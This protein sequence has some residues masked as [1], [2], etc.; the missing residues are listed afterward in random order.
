MHIPTYPPLN[1]TYLAAYLREYSRYKYIIRLVDINSSKDPIN[2]ILKFRPDI[3]G[4]TTL[5]SHLIEICEISKKIRSI[6]KNILL[7]CGGA[8]AAISP[9]DLLINGEFDIAVMGEGEVSFKELVESYVENNKKLTPGLLKNIKGI[10][11]KEEDK[12]TVNAARELICDLDTIPHPDRE[13]LDNNYYSNRY[14]VIRTKGT[15]G[16]TTIA[17]S[18]G[19]PFNCIFCC[20][21]I[22]NNRKVRMHSVKYIIDEI[23][24]IVL[25]FKGKWLFFTDDIFLINKEL[26]SN[27]CEELMKKKLNK[28]IKWECQL[29]S[30]LVTGD[31]LPL[32]KLM[33]KAGCEQIDYGFE[34]G[35]QRMLTLIKG[36]GITV[37]DHQRAIDI[38]NKANL[39]VF[40]SFIL[41]TPTET[42]EELMDTK[43]FILKNYGKFYRFQVTFLI[44]YP[45]TPVYD[46]CIKKGFMSEDYFAYLSSDKEGKFREGM[47]IFS[48]SIPAEILIDFKR[49]LD[50]L[51]LKKIDLREKINWLMFNMFHNTQALKTGLKWAFKKLNKNN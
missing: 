24:Q 11:F 32:L 12:I 22:A 4:L 18:R 44:P 20:V 48:D 40:G 19:C 5:S 16:V 51:S 21:N 15:Y 43:K 35:N 10:A 42:Y 34:S 30:N 29:R 39:K 14:Y 8:H 25:R 17:A 2:E 13:L 47:R 33:K 38:T 31:T 41:G 1:L 23:E 3:L 45:G 7:V 28:K 50:S 27:L 9:Q 46:L 49:E 36:K 37:E 26:V 6:N